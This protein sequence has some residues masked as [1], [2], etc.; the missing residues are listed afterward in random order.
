M[1]I[2]LHCFGNLNQC[3]EGVCHVQD[4]RKFSYCNVLETHSNDE[5]AGP[6]AESS[7]G[8]GGRAGPLTEQ[9]SNNKPGDWSRPDFEENYE[10]K[11]CDH[12][13]VAHPSK[14]AL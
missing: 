4:F 9:F 13:H 11:N 5:V 12:A 6:V 10:E 2:P 7:Y 1:S 3:F 8:Y 14:S